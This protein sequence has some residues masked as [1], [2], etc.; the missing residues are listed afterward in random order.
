MTPDLTGHR[1]LVVADDPLLAALVVEQ[2]RFKAEF[3]REGETA[4]QAL[5]R[6]R[7]IAA[8]LLDGGGAAAGSDMLVSRAR[9]LGIEVMVFGAA[10]SLHRHAAWAKRQGVRTFALPQGIDALASALGSLL[11][12][13]A[14]GRPGTERRATAERLA[15]GT[16]VFTDDAGRR[17]SVYDRRGGPRRQTDRRFVS[18]TGE[19]LHCEL[20]PGESE[21]ITAVALAG[22]LSRAH[23]ERE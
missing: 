17:W 8:L 16:L 10:D 2:E 21:H 19:V 15:D 11:A 4:D 1:I 13:P 9:K 3:P 5:A 6:V 12:D 7:P 20:K 14:R 22:Q 18:E 23:P